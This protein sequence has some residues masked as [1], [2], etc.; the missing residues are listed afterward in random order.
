M[1]NVIHLTDAV[2]SFDHIRETRQALAYFE[3]GEISMDTV[4]TFAAYVACVMGAGASLIFLH[5]A[6]DAL[7]DRLRNNGIVEI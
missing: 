1:R 3:G 2:R 6:G 5:I 7:L 4:F